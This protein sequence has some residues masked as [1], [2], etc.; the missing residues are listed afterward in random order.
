[1][2]LTIPVDIAPNNVPTIGVASAESVGEMTP[3]EAK[4]VKRRATIKDAV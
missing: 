4:M 2:T 1:M 3:K